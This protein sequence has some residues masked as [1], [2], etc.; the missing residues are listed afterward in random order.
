MKIVKMPKKISNVVWLED[1]QCD[2]YSKCKKCKNE[3]SRCGRCQV[4]FNS[5]VYLHYG[6]SD[7]VLQNAFRKIGFV[8]VES[9][10][11][12]LSYFQIDAIQILTFKNIRY[13]ENKFSVNIDL[14]RVVPGGY[15]L[16]RRARIDDENRFSKTI[17]IAKQ[18]YPKS[19]KAPIE[20]FT[21]V[22]DEKNYQ[23]P[24]NVRS[25]HHVYLSQIADMILN[26]MR[27]YVSSNQKLMCK[28]NRNLTVNSF[29]RSMKW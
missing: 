16:E 11:D 18:S 4:V 3:T 29:L 24:I 20:N 1:A 25:F 21:I 10:T 13:I 12:A 8:A 9:F 2:K 26:D 23:S 22:F 19:M 14:Y 27:K 5:L 15:E 17:N 28:F 6:I 7:T